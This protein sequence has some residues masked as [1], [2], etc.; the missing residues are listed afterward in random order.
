MRIKPKYRVLCAVLASILILAAVGLIWYRADWRFRF[1]N[2]V[3]IYPKPVWE[4]VSLQN[5][6]TVTVDELTTLGIERNDLMLLINST[7]PLPD[8]FEPLLEEYNGARM[9]PE[10]V[11][12]YIALRD[13]LEAKTGQRIYVSSDYRSAKEQEE[14]LV[15][16]PDGIAAE[17]GHSE[18]EAGL[19]LDVYVKGFGGM[20]LIKTSAGREL[21]RICKDY[22]FVIRYPEGKERITGTPYEPWHLRYVGQPHAS[23]MDRYGLTLEEYIALLEVGVWYDV[24]DYYVGRFAEN[25]ILF[26]SNES[27]EGCVSPDN[28]GYFIIT[29]KKS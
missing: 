23:L 9:H 17:V 7:H 26:P 12:H 1:A 3:R 25:E 24:G 13:A 14:I 18:H 15:T 2:T 19:A 8:G 5:T 21:A 28:T 11:E 27:L 29:L 22:G 20:S 4:S 6:T 16:S 10:M